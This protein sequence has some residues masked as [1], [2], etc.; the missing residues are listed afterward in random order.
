MHSAFL[1]RAVTPS[2]PPSR[3]LSLSSA[4]LLF[5]FLDCFLFPL[6]LLAA[7]A[8]LLVLDVAAVAGLSSS[9]STRNRVRSPS[10]LRA[11]T[12]AISFTTAIHS[13]SKQVRACLLWSKLSETKCFRT[14][15]RVSFPA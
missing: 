7:L 11:L 12:I 4:A 6:P 8:T 9:C 5:F 1:A 3:R 10:L 2:S 13:A 15:A 14:A